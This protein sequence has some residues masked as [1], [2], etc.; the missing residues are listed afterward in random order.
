V[1]DSTPFVIGVEARCSDGVCGHVVQVVID[2]IRETVTH[3]IV[4]PEHREGLGR[5][6]PIDLV[7]P[8]S[9]HVEIRATIAEFEALEVG[10]ETQFLPGSEGSLQYQPEQVLLWPYFGG[11][12]TLPVTVEVIPVGEVAVRRGEQ[13]HAID[14][15]IGEVKGLVIE[16]TNHHV[17]HFV[18][19][20]GHLFGR[21]DVAIPI[22]AVKE[23]EASGV[24][25]TLSKKQVEDLP[26]FE[27]RS[28]T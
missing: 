2:P 25:L 8:G 13:V 3:L 26:A 22:S 5:L 6:V 7:D 15:R 19:K 16:P 18:L 11:N 9:D 14:G 4:E 12:T 1:P 24:S 20:E 17:T 23:V 21:K 10:E 28:Q 27:F